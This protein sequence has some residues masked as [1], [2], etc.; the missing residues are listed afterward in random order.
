MDFAT[1][2]GTV[3]GPVLQI[4]AWGLGLLGSSDNNVR[5]FKQ[6]VELSYKYNLIPVE[7][8]DGFANQEA[9][10]MKRAEERRKARESQASNSPDKKA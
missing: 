4:V 3:W 8:K 7:I 9:A 1:I 10:L 2:F 5:I 6:L